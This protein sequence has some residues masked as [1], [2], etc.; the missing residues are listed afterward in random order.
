MAKMEARR[1]S[2]SGGS[3][4]PRRR[5]SSKQNQSEARSVY[6]L[7]DDSQRYA[8]VLHLAFEGASVR[9]V[10]SMLSLRYSDAPLFLGGVDNRQHCTGSFELGEVFQVGSE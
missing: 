5:R 4:P 2:L 1:R 7:G 9:L 10:N 8:D 6:I 3:T